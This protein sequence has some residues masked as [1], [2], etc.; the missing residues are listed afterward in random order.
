MNLQD[1]KKMS[2]SELVS[3]AETHEIENASA[4]RKQDLLFAILKKL[5][6]KEISIYGEG[7]VEILQ[8][9]YAF[10]RSSE[11]NYLPGPD[12]IYISPNQ[13]RRFAIRTGDTVGG[14]IRSPSTCSAKLRFRSNSTCCISNRLLIA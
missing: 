14:E 9:G 2:P 10:L 12:D 11:A 5:S 7:V 6:E 13:V 8:E 4:L 1:L 3:F